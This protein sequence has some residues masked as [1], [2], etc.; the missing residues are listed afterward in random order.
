MDPKIL[1][2]ELV[3]A[4]TETKNGGTSSAIETKEELY[5]LKVEDRKGETAMKFEDAQP[6]IECGLKEIE[7]KRIYEAW[8]ARLREKAYIKTFDVKLFQ[9]K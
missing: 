2:P 6:Q 5:I 7:M 3:K 9:S 8:T 4:I 1:R